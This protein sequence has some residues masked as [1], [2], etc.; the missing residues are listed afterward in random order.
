[1]VLDS[2]ARLADAWCRRRLCSVILI[3]LV[4]MAGCERKPTRLPSAPQPPRPQVEPRGYPKS[5]LGNA[6]LSSALLSYT[7][8]CNRKGA[9]VRICKAPAEMTLRQGAADT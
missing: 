1:M 3:C 2:I 8:Q 7:V 6:T 5:L 9:S 4:T